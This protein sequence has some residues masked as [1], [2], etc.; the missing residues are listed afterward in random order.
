MKTYLFNH[1]KNIQGW[2]SKRKLVIFSV[3]DYGNVRIASK[4]ASD[5][6]KRS[7]IPP[8][9]IFDWYDSMETREDLEALFEV[10]TSVKDK[11]GNHPVFTPYA[12]P[13]NIDFEAIEQNNYDD[14]RYELLPV[15]FEKLAAGDPKAYEGTWALWQ[16]GIRKG[17]MK[18]QFHG[19]EHLNLHVFRD[20]LRNKN[21]N[22]LTSLKH[23]SYIALPEHKNYRQGWTSAY[24]F[25][26]IE[27]TSGMLDNIKDGLTCFSQVYG[28]EAEVFTPSATSFP[29]NIEAGLPETGLK[30]FDRPRHT[31]RYQGNG[32]Y[33]KEYYKLGEVHSLPVIVRNVV[34][35]PAT[36]DY[37]NDWL[38]FTMKQIEAAFFWGKP[39]H[40]S[41][42][43]TNFSGH[44]DA[45]NRKKG[46]N[47]LQQLLKEIVKRWPE[48]EFISSDQLGDIVYKVN[49]H[50]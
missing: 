50:N 22:L 18:P 45:N 40:L 15:T 20:L 3:D 5:E 44:I 10:L 46:L 19:R 8:V 41:S 48:V 13:C 25:R 27:E 34:F 29:P 31:N 7:G 28:Y 37:T 6:L 14:Y 26:K 11:N 35:E 33:K 9:S 2:R 42:H 30:Y 47:T 17:L 43:R 23:R 49:F 4:K 1:L 39:A 24:A 32:E 38:N 16:E 36:T 12:L 21:Q